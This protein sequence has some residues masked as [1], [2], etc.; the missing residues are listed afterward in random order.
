MY[1]IKR[2]FRATNEKRFLIVITP[3][4]KTMA[5]GSNAIAILKYRAA[6]EEGKLIF[7]EGIGIPWESHCFHHPD[8]APCLWFLVSWPLLL[9]FFLSPL[10]ILFAHKGP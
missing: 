7:N 9:L 8:N 4:D 1:K 2:A 10:L 5:V 3:D 6:R